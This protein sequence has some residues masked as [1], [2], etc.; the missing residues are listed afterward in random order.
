M[1]NHSLGALASL[2]ALAQTTG[3]AVRPVLL[4]FTRPTGRS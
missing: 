4:P 1:K 3:A 2:A